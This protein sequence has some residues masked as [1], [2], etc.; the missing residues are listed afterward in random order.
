VKSARR[1]SSPLVFLLFLLF[2][3]VLGAGAL[4][5]PSARALGN[6]RH[7]GPRGEFFHITDIAHNAAEGRLATCFKSYRL[8]LPDGQDL[9]AFMGFSL[10]LFFYLPLL[11]LRDVVTIYN[12]F[13]VLTMALNGFC[14]YLFARQLTGRLWP[15]VLGGALFMISPFALLKIEMG[16]VQ[17]ALLWWIPLFL[18]DL[19]R[20]LDRPAPRRAALAG[21]VWALMLLTYAPYA[22]YALWALAILGGARFVMTPEQRRALLLRAWPFAL[23]ALAAF[24]VLLISLPGGGVPPKEPGAAELPPLAVAMAPNGC[25]D[26]LR[27]FRFAPYPDFMPRT[28]YLRLGISL[29]GFFLSAAAVVHAPRKALPL[30][31]VADFFLLVAIG[32]FFHT[33]G[34]ILSRF[35]LP[36]YVFAC[37][38]P[39]G[40]RLGFPIRALPFVEIALAGLTALIAAHW[41][42]PPRRRFVVPAAL[43]AL[44]LCERALLLP[45]L[46]PPGTADAA[47]PAHLRWLRA[48]G[49]TVLHLPF[50]VRGNDVRHYLYVTAR[51]D[52]RMLNRYL[53]FWSAYPVPPLPADDPEDVRDYVAMLIED[54]CDLIAIHPRLLAAE[55]HP[56]LVPP[57]IPIETYDLADTRAFAPW[58]GPPVFS[59]AAMIA[60]H[61]PNALPPADAARI[62]PDIPERE[63][64][65]WYDAHPGRFRRPRTVRVHHFF[66]PHAASNRQ[67]R[68][69]AIAAALAQDDAATLALSRTLSAADPQGR[70]W[71]DLGYVARG[72]LPPDVDEALFDMDAIGEV[73]AL[74]RDDGT[75]IVRLMDIRPARQYPFEEVRAAVADAVRAERRAARPAPHPGAPRTNDMVRIAG[76]TFRMGSTEAEI[77]AA[78]EMA[79]RFA[80][81]T[82][83]VRRAWF[84]DEVLRTVTV[85]PFL[86]DRREVTHGEYRAFLEATGY[87]PPPDG[88]GDDAAQPDMPVL[89]VSLEDARAYAAW[90]G[91]RLPTVEEWAWA[92]RGAE[93]RLY[94]WGDEPP[95]GTRANYADAGSGFPWRDLEHDDGHA[96]PAPVGRY[97]AGATPR[98]LLDMAG[99]AREWT[100]TAR[101]GVTDTRTGHIWSLA[102]QDQVPARLRSAPAIM[103]AVRGGAWNNAADDMRCSDERMLPPDTRHEALGFRCVLDV[104]PLDEAREPPGPRRQGDV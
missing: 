32:P 75:H 16:F 45:E 59:N 96:G 2:A 14:A 21:A 76:G 50:N 53:G 25:L 72:C 35:P 68:A 40:E 28:A 24:V 103:Y 1:G 51:T 57:E 37:C 62:A 9:R 41:S 7:A 85:G 67:E 22:W 83:A 98:G 104:P 92:A 65:A 95:D 70:R 49:G 63:L 39:W 79:Q 66:V 97:P 36:S 61:V 94:P 13:L 46:F 71:G 8:A 43:L 64:R 3:A 69:A 82:R 54:G 47:L 33:G 4:R 88:I 27:L 91:K 48:E 87:P 44:V 11:W 100:G 60:Y 34:R 19:L 18:R 55:I 26:L 56:M 99:N 73:A 101:W 23:P 78:Y 15:S 38:F 30:A 90:A 12:V 81:R 29:V 77:Q 58:C 6:L 74:E 10:H 102:Q 89:G 5:D 93:R 84:E 80:G 86:M 31:I 52:T 42:A 17:K 20:Y